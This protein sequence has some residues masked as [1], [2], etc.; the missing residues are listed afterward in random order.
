MSAAL[1]AIRTAE[2][3]VGAVVRNGCAWRDVAVDD[4]VAEIGAVAR[5]RIAEAAGA[6][7]AE[8]DLRARRC[9]ER[10]LAEQLALGAVLRRQ[11]DAA[12]RAGTA[13]GQPERRR[14]G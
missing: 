1:P 14:L 4:V 8:P 2:R 13:A 3:A 11:R 7:R 10:S 12:G 6:R 5:G 9:G